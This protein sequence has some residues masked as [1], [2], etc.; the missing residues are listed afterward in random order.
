MRSDSTDLNDSKSSEDN[1]SNSPFTG[2]RVILAVTEYEEQQAFGEMLV[3]M[4]IDVLIAASAGEALQLL[5][6]HPSDLL[7][8]DVNQP[9][10]HGWPMINKIREINELRDLPITVITDQPNMGITVARVNYLSRPVSIA[11]L[12]QAVVNALDGSG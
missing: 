7:I 12:R 3:E 5:E 2:R 9:D 1:M 8:M 11:R 4:D 10:M 6:D